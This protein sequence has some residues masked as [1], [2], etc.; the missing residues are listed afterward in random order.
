MPSIQIYSAAEQVANHLRSEILRGRWAPT[1]PG[2]YQLAEELGVNH[3]TVGG[4]LRLL[5]RDGLLVNQGAGRNRRIVLP[6]GERAVRPMRVGL[7]LHD[8]NEDRKTELVIELRHALTEAG[9][10]PIFPRRTLLE[11]NMDVKRIARIVRATDVDAWVIYV[12]S[13]E[14][15]QW[16]AARPEPA[17]ALAGRQ[18]GVAIAGTKP[19]MEQAYAEAARQL[20]R[21]GHRRIVLL[22]R[23]VRR[24]PEPGRSEKAFLMALEDEGVRTGSYN[25]PDWEDTPA[26]LDRMLDALFQVTPPTALLVDEPFL[27]TAVRQGLSSRGLQIPRDVSLVCTTNDPTFAWCRPSVAHLDY[28]ARLVVRR[29][30]RWVA[31]IS[32]GREDTKQTTVPACFVDGGSIAAAMPA[33]S[34]RIGGRRDRGTPP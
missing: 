33:P 3:K 1:L 18:E 29:M 28:D 11:L 15:L 23:S 32:R 26:G 16:F 7:L 21:L 4:A 31:N 24:L 2:V 13:R 27:Y 14:V 20:V 22:C 10:V 6:S 5:E 19:N 30:V 25:L 12:A 17:F 34:L 9:H 8:T